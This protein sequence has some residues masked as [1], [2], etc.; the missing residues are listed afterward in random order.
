MSG[1][2]SFDLE[3]ARQ[4]LH[5]LERFRETLNQQWSKVL[6][7]WSNLKSTWRDEQFDRFESYFMK[8]SSTYEQALEDCENYSLFLNRQI[9]IYENEKSKLSLLRKLKATADI[10]TI[11][12]GSA[13]VSMPTQAQNPGSPL[14]FSQANV[15][16]KLE[17]NYRDVEKLRTQREKDNRKRDIETSRQSQEQAIASGGA[18]PPK[19]TELSDRCQYQWLEGD[20]FSSPKMK[21]FLPENSSQEGR[22]REIGYIIIERDSKN[23]VR[24]KDTFIADSYRKQGI[25]AKLLNQLEEKLPEGTE[26][27]LTENQAQKFWKKRG[28]E[29]I[30]ERYYRKFVKK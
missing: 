23:R 11:L 19:P 27:Y 9:K 21:V 7:R 13:S 4:M 18:D 30:S 15:S 3:D 20:E 5:Q 12:G 10:V 25:G 1:Q 17:D 8:L 26:L 2:T 16:E 29:Q 22:S 6:D 28:F 24:I 14:Q